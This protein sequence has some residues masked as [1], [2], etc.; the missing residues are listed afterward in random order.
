MFLL[1][2]QFNCRCHNSGGDIVQ[3]SSGI[4]SSGVLDLV[5]EMRSQLHPPDTES[6]AKDLGKRA[7]GND[8]AL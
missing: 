5:S 2:S 3:G 8:A 1:Q 4:D 6:R 7:V